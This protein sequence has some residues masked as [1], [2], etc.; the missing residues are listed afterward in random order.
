V[1]TPSPAPELPAL[2]GAPAQ[3]ADAWRGK[4]E[5]PI[6]FEDVTQDGRFVLEALPNAIGPTI[7]RGILTKNRSFISLM[8]AGVLPML[9]RFVLQG[10]PGPFS[11]NATVDAEGACR[12]VRT[13]DG[14]EP[15]YALDI[16]AELY[17]PLGKTYGR[18]RRHGERALAGRIWAEQMFTRPFAP[19]GQRRVTNLDFEG[20][21]DV[22]DSRP[23]APSPASIAN[24][25]AGAHALEEAPRVDASPVVFGLVHTDSNMH[26]NSLAYLRMFEEAA[27]RRF[28]ELGKT[29]SWLGRTLEI[30]YKKP[31]FAGQSLRVVQQAFETDGKPGIAASLVDAKDTV[32]PE[33]LAKARPHTYARIVFDG[34]SNPQ[35]G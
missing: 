4:S 2:P 15:R 24:V 8:N 3:P 1:T 33:A 13:D 14:G 27:I 34:P 23:G 18:A 30:V 22:R 28:V 35:Q 10:T 21:P 20:A 5:V 32:S 17:A 26:V 31:C 6:R 12:M 9:T 19:P 29:A 11:A 16:W 7:W 25:P